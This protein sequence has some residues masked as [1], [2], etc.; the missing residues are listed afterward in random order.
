MTAAE[1]KSL[2]DRVQKQMQELQQLQGQLQQLLHHGSLW[3]ADRI[4]VYSM[5]FSLRSLLATVRRW[6]ELHA[7]RVQRAWLEE[8]KQSLQ[9][10]TK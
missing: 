9:E 6:Q 4:W 7:E 10:D 3:G 8:Q 5:D 1:R 2:Y